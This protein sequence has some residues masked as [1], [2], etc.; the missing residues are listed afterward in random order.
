MEPS[1]PIFASDDHPTQPTNRGSL[2][3][4]TVDDTLFQNCSAVNSFNDLFSAMTFPSSP[5]HTDKAYH[6]FKEAVNQ[7]MLSAGGPLQRATHIW[8]NA[9]LSPGSGDN[10]P[11]NSVRSWILRNDVRW[12]LS[13]ELDDT[14]GIPLFWNPHMRVHQPKHTEW[15]WWEKPGMTARPITKFWYGQ[16]LPHHILEAFD[17][18]TV[19]QVLAL[20]I[21]H[22][23]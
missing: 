2:P 23:A 19:A 14:E 7:L 22:I 13:D 15:V 3:A 12:N 17:N 16:I 1:L 8:R 4:L 20:G 18:L 21:Q 6:L 9:Y 10:S 5:L 11:G